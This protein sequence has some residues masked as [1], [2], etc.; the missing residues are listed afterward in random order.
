MIKHLYYIQEYQFH[1]T[2][3]EANIQYFTSMITGKVITIFGKWK[4]YFPYKFPKEV[5]IWLKKQEEI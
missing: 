3:K 2:K 1:I 5:V 4:I